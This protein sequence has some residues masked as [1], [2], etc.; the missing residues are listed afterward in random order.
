MSGSPHESSSEPSIRDFL[1]FLARLEA[2]TVSV[3]NRLD[4]FYELKQKVVSME[5]DLQTLWVAMDSKYKGVSDKVD[6]REDKLESTDF[7]LA[8][9]KIESLER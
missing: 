9:D 7:G 5:G 4:A 3:E 6:A 8:H 2:K 1:I